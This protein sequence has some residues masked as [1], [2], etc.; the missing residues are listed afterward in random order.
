MWP[1]HPAPLKINW[2]PWKGRRSTHQSHSR[3][4]CQFRRWVWPCGPKSYWN[5]L[6]WYNDPSLHLSWQSQS[7]SLNKVQVYGGI[8]DHLPSNLLVCSLVQSKFAQFFQVLGDLL[9]IPDS[10]VHSDDVF[11]SKTARKRLLRMKNEARNGISLLMSVQLVL[12]IESTGLLKV[13]HILR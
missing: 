2:V 5:S 4:R 6:Q 10:I 13:S 3:C 11:L 12:S 7:K 1:C 8:E 9:L